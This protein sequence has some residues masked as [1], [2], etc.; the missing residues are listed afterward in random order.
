V[1]R[2]VKGL[3][4]FFLNNAVLVADMK[5]CKDEFIG[6]IYFIYF[7]IYFFSGVNVSY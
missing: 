4:I 1:C 6:N 3:N 2:V 7:F 5:K